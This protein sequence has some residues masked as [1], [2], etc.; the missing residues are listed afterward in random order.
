MASYYPT[1]D[2][3]QLDGEWCCGFEPYT[4]DNVHDD[5]LAALKKQ[6]LTPDS[7]RRMRTKAFGPAA[8]PLRLFYRP[9]TSDCDDYLR[10]E[11]TEQFGIL[12]ISYIYTECLQDA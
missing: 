9:V 3:A 7:I 10:H 8:K 5:Y 2:H 11:L 1:G 4:T 6:P 12:C